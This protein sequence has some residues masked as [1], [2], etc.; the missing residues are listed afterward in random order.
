MV[1]GRVAD[2]A[3]AVAQ[4]LREKGFYRG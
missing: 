1:A 3:K 4:I 2:Q